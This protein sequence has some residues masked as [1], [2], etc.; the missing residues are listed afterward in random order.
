MASFEDTF[1]RADAAD[2]GA[3]WTGSSWSGEASPS[4]VSN[5]CKAV[6]G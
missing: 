3:N 4:I 2:L 5:Q 1:V 6:G